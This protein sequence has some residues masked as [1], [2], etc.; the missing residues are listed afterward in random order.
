MAEHDAAVRAGHISFE[1]AEGI[2][3]RS[4]KAPLGGPRAVE[5]LGYFGAV[6]LAVA[7]LVL[8]VDT[9]LGDG[10]VEGL[11]FGSLENVPAGLIALIGSAILLVLGVRFAGHAAGAIRRAGGFTLLA[12][13]GLA[14]VAFGFLLYDLDLGDFTP[15]VRLLPVAAVALFI[16]MRLPSMPTQLAL[17]ATAVQAVSAI[18][19]LIQVEDFTEPATMVLSAAFG[20]TPDTGGWITLLVGTALGVAWIWLGMTGRVRPRNTAFALGAFYT[21][22]ESIQLFGTADGWIAL[23]L[24]VAAGFAWGA[25]TWQSSVLGGFATVAVTVLIA[26]FV[27]L[28]VDSPTTTTWVIAYGVP[29]LL[30]LGGAWWMSQTKPAPMAAMAAPAAAAMA[31]AAAAQA[32]TAAAT[33]KATATKPATKK[34]VSAKKPTTTAKKPAAKKATTTAKKTTTTAKTPATKAAA[35]V[36]KAAT[37]VK[38][39]TTT[40]KKPAPKKPTR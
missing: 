27:S 37:T 25:E 35:P 19:V 29:G 22:I 20:N 38:K 9:A 18:L 12:A 36:K 31:V 34:A 3:G 24:V 40:A 11:I 33:K 7:T 2:A 10:G 16:W 5:V 14:S 26:Q 28:V 23:S 30:A 6:A 17:F 32:P 39:A 21:W 8:A 13:Y 1:Q 4:G 15:L